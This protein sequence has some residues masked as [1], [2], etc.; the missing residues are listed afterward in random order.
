MG[1]TVLG[2]LRRSRAV[3]GTSNTP[4][5]APQGRTRSSFVKELHGGWGEQGA[6]SHSLR[7]FDTGVTRPG[8]GE[9][10]FLSVGYVDDQPFVGFDSDSP[11]QREEPR[12]AWIERVEQEEPGYW[13]QQTRTS[14]ANMPIAREGLENLRGY[15]NQSKGGVHTVQA[16]YGCEVSPELTFQRGFIQFAYDGQD[17]LALD[18]D[19]LT[20]TAA[21]P[22]AVNTKREWEAERSFA[23]GWK[24]Y[25]EEK[26]VLWVKKYLEMGKEALMRT[27]PPSARVTHHTAPYGQMTLRCRAWDFYP[28]E[29][30]LTWLKDGEEQ[31]QDTEFIE[32]RP[33]GD[34][35]FQKWAAVDVTSGQEGRYTCRVQHEGLSEPLTLQW[36]PESSSTWLVVGGIAAA[37]LILIAVVA[38]VRMWRRKHSGNDSAQGS[39]MSLT[40]KA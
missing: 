33:A 7:Y 15:F 38:G 30:S 21:V 17:Y 9:P 23:E 4:P 20:W 22:P 6:G 3:R 39:D 16:M 11:G 25:L 26:C 13:E 27:D 31:P 19:T 5:R 1:A 40:A 32:T 12:A 2:A 18:R 28:K 8:L 24:A 36:E 35:T 37:L 14:R 34:G 29:I 10:R